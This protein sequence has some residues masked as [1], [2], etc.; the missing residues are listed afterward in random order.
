M[1]KK[2]HKKTLHFNINQSYKKFFNNKNI[3]IVGSSSSLANSLIKSEALSNANLYGLS[4]K[5]NT[6]NLTKNF[7]F[8]FTNEDCDF[9]EI[10]NFFKKNK[11][12]IDS[13]VL[14]SGVHYFN[15]TKN[16]NLIKSLNLFKVN[17][18]LKIYLISKLYKNNLIKKDSSICFISSTSSK[19]VFEGTLDYSSSFSALDQSM[20]IMAKEFLDKKIRVNAISVGFANSSTLKKSRLAFTDTQLKNLKSTYPLGFVSSNNLDQLIF[21]ILSDASKQITGQNYILDS[22]SNLF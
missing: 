10:I 3:L 14:F 20:Q 21:F 17:Y 18:F 13:I 4:N 9:N 6:K 15:N 19:K 22:G 1:I 11:I 8:D 12:Y 7:N 16:F 5:K 2:N